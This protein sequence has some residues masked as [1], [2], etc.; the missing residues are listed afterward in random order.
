MEASH[1][2]RAEL[3]EQ[4]RRMR[5]QRC[6]I[7]SRSHEGWCPS[8]WDGI[9]CWASTAGGELAVQLCPDYITGFDGQENATR[10]CMPSGDWYWSPEHNNTW[11]NFSRCYRERY[12]TVVVEL[13]GNQG[14]NSS[15][16]E[17]MLPAIKGISKTGY[18]LSFCSL[19]LALCI[20]ASFKKLRCQR[21]LLHMH[22]FGSFVA[23]AFAWLLK[24]L[25][26]VAGVG[27][28]SDVLVKDGQN[29]LLGDSLQDNWR[30]KA[31]TSLW[32]YC[33]LSNYSWILM[34]GLYLYHLVFCALLADPNASIVVYALVGWAMPGVSVGIWVAL[35][36]LYEDTYCWTTHEHGLI[37]Q[38]IRLPITLSVAIN[39]VLFVRIVRVL[40]TKLESTMSERRRRLKK[41]ARSTMVLVPLFGAHYSVFL[42]VSYGVTLN[43]SLEALWLLT[44]QAFASVQGFFVALLYCFLNDE[45][46]GELRRVLCPRPRLRPRSA[47]S[48]SCHTAA[49]VAAAAAAEQQSRMAGCCRRLL[50]AWRHG[51]RTLSHSAASTQDIGIETRG[52]SLASSRGFLEVSGAGP[53]N[54]NPV[55]CRPTLCSDADH[56]RHSLCSNV[57]TRPRAATSN[58][59][60]HLRLLSCPSPPSPPYPREESSP[61]PM[62]QRRA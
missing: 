11:T 49:A 39:C 53:G 18:S 16:F 40:L 17:M 36:A 24:E 38:V 3:Q 12:I 30:C 54:G 25:L 21:N 47:S 60:S 5:E 19:L 55:S 37:F 33:I 45:V 1:S 42:L 20:F 62:K 4:T 43:E 14:K 61:S 26:F 6:L 48:C 22:L 52:G 27:L 15:M 13:P 59:E 34:E 56:G 46:R 8:T 29:Y 58:D 10:Q 2:S 50:A 35:R 32:Q 51:R 31:F 57:S 7:G 28:S 9:A 44:D 41:W 23:R